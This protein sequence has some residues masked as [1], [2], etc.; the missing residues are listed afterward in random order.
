[1]YILFISMKCDAKMIQHVHYLFV[2]MF[3]CDVMVSL[4]P[5]MLMMML[6][7]KDQR[8]LLMSQT[9]KV[10]RVYVCGCIELVHYFGSS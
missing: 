4:D 2:S 5:T 1:M 3:W 8:K 9:L 10:F 7:E 6:S